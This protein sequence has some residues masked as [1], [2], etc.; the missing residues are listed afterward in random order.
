MELYCTLGYKPHQYC[1]QG[2]CMV[3][4]TSPPS[5]G[6]GCA[7]TVLLLGYIFFGWKTE[8]QELGTDAGGPKFF[9][10][11][12][13][14]WAGRIFPPKSLTRDRWSCCCCQ[15]EEE[16]RHGRYSH[17]LSSSHLYTQKSIC[18]DWVEGPSRYN[19]RHE[20]IVTFSS[21]GGIKLLWEELVQWAGLAY[22][23]CYVLHM[24]GFP[25]SVAAGHTN[26]MACDTFL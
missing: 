26:V 12:I 14:P 4:K 13:S 3:F 22:V 21:C 10:L 8:V 19:I 16:R 2:L 5:R 9:L 15:E 1:R 25:G 23:L 20:N 24:L 11:L 7:F 17:P 6:G 18:H